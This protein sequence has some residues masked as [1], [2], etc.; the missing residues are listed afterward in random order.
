MSNEKKDLTRIEDLGEFTHD[1]NSTTDFS[2]PEDYSG[3]VPDVPSNEDSEINFSSELNFTNTEDFAPSTPD[4]DSSHL[5]NS[6]FIQDQ[7]I[8][9]GFEN[10]FGEDNFETN[11]S[12]TTVEEHSFLQEN[13]QDL[14]EDKW[15]LDHNKK[16]EIE[17]SLPFIVPEPIT[18]QQREY[19]SPETFE[20]LKKFSESASFN[21]G[22]SEGNPSFSLLIKNVRFIEDIND[23][24]ALLNDFKLLVDSE[25]Q[26]KAR[27]MRGMLLVPRV[28]E[29]TAIFL[30]HKLRRFDIDIEVGLSDEIHPPRHQE[31]P[32]IGIVSKHSLYQNQNHHFN[33]ENPKFDISDIIISASS[34]LDGYQVVRYL[35]IASEHKIVGGHIVEDESSEEVI[36]LYHELA[37]KLKVHALKANSNAVVGLNYQLT[38][39]PSD[40]GVGGHKYRLSCTGNLVWIKKI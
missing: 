31:R 17:T 16:N 35:G 34:T 25:D 18:A 15:E 40:F 14:P 29:F 7:P 26:T 6:E 11:N 38:P 19:K 3:E 32:E 27:L 39:L 23:I 13:E 21:L 12:D 20:D 10:N 36:L 4:E 9:E 2:T 28:S 30:A 1:L 37:Q 22:P 24:V 5:V 33:F 8:S